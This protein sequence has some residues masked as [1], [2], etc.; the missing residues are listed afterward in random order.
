M[1][2]CHW[3]FTLCCCSFWFSLL[4]SQICC[5]VFFLS[6]CSF[7]NSACRILSQGAS[8]L[9][10][11]SG[12]W[13][14]ANLS[15]LSPWNFVCKGQEPFLCVFSFSSLSTVRWWPGSQARA[16]AYYPWIRYVHSMLSLRMETCVVDRV[17]RRR[18]PVEIRWSCSSSEERNKVV[19]LKLRRT[20]W[21]KSNSWR[22]K[23]G[24]KI[25]THIP[26][27]ANKLHEE[28]PTMY[29][30]LTPLST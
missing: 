25:K 17:G 27:C 11:D 6:A 22:I 10:L 28:H 29:T 24:L 2:F 26:A 21:S 16:K 1:W 3:S 15:S 20:Q 9:Y 5:C 19:T 18:R 7:S 8:L 23:G 30:T 13:L 12:C 4:N 14:S